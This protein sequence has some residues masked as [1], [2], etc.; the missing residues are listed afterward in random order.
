[1]SL[2]MTEYSRTIWFDTSIKFFIIEYITRNHRFKM[3]KKVLH[4]EFTVS[5]LF[6]V[7]IGKN[8]SIVK[9]SQIIFS[10]RQNI[11]YSF[12]SRQAGYDTMSFYCTGDQARIEIYE[13]PFQKWL[14]SSIFPNRQQELFYYKFVQIK[15]QIKGD[16]LRKC[17]LKKM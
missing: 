1:M 12:T 6:F 10:E 5:L 2:K 13:W 9:Y 4:T 7:N 16:E 15:K 8:N 14:I 11:W 17:N 3:K